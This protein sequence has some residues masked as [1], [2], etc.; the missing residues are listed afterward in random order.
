[1]RNEGQCA[2]YQN[3]HKPADDYDFVVP[4]DAAEDTQRQAQHHLREPVS[5][6]D[7]AYYR[8]RDVDDDQKRREERHVDI[9][10]KPK[11][12][13]YYKDK[14]VL[15]F[16]RLIIHHSRI[17]AMMKLINIQVSQGRS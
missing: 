4:L 17:C 1:M 2:G 8:S 5:P 12:H 14:I 9:L 16:H 13:H 3:Y 10:R 11:E 15:F 6:R 7:N